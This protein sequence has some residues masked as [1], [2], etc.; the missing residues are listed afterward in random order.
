MQFPP[1]DQNFSKAKVTS[2]NLQPSVTLI[3]STF[4]TFNPEKAFSLQKKS[5][6]ASVKLSH[7][8]LCFYAIRLRYKTSILH[9][10][11]KSECMCARAYVCTCQCMSHVGNFF[12]S[13]QQEI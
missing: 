3:T 6:F 4:Q 9:K 1:A 8:V 13:F 7:G 10:L 5:D 11:T 2:I 12:A